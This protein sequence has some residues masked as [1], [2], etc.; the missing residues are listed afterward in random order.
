MP[1]FSVDVNVFTFVFLLVMFLG[2]QMQIR[3][4]GKKLDDIA[5]QK[6]Q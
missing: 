5:Q 2:L 4:I 6:K 1:E 3:G